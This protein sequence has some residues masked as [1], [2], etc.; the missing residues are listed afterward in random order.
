[1]G[2]IVL[3]AVVLLLLFAISGPIGRLNPGWRYPD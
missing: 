1:M 3:C 2:W